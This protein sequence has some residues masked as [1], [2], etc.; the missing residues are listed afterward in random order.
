MN[1]L[2][3]RSSDLANSCTP[4]KLYTQTGVGPVSEGDHYL[5]RLYL[6]L[7]K[8]AVC[9]ILYED[10]SVWRY[11]NHLKEFRTLD[12]FDLETRLLGEDAPAEAH[13]MIGWHRLSNVQNCAEV[14]F[15]KSIQGD[16][17]ETGVLRGGSAIFMRAILKA[18]NCIDRR[19]FACDTFVRLA[20]P[21][22]SLQRFLVWSGCTILRRVVRIPSDRW[23]LALFRFFEQRQRNFPVSSNPSMEWVECFL[24]IVAN[25][26][27]VFGFSEKD[28]TSLEAV[29]SHFARY[30][31]LD[32]Q[33]V[34]L[35]GLFS[36]TLPNSGMQSIALLRCDADSF[37]ST[38]GVLKEL[39]PKVSVG[40]FVII[41]DYNRFVDC[42]LAVDRFRAEENSTEL[43]IAIDNLSVYWQKSTSMARV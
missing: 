21:S 26:D 18:H 37:E 30:G 40:G 16:F 27:R 1:L 10:I 43:L 14:I 25:L 41:D 7:V 4:W 9:N 8:R 15:E 20:P 12:R 34:F 19:V 2:S 11:N 32:S 22:S 42:K 29:Q 38:Y 28:R 23:K 13:T 6:D 39:Y 33:V 5:R 36:D 31:L 35:K 24:H 3:A 17:V